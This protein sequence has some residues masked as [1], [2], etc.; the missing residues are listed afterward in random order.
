MDCAGFREAHATYSKLP[1]DSEETEEDEDYTGHLNDCRSC[2][3]FFMAEAVRERGHQPESFPCVHIAYY[4]TFTCDESNDPWECADAVLVR[5]E[6]DAHY[7]IPVRDGGSS[8]IEVR[9]CPWCG[10]QI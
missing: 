9:Y 8:Y 1:A 5:G 4:S 2:G 3:D 6:S 10:K 7:G